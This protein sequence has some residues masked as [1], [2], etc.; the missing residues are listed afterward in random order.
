MIPPKQVYLLVLKLM[1]RLPLALVVPVK[2][3]SAGVVLLLVAEAQYV[4]LLVI[5][6]LFA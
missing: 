1:V 6:V 4:G 3:S 2:P 5:R